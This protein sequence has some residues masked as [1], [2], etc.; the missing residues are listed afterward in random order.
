MGNSA[1]RLLR[2]IAL[3][4]EAGVPIIAVIM[5]FPVFIE[6]SAGATISGISVLLM[7]L[8]AIPLKNKIKMFLRS[9]SIPILWTVLFVI[10][11]AIS[12]IIKEMVVVTFVG[13]LANIVGILLEFIARCI[14]RR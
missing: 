13:M 8:C 7:I 1:S 6:R 14:D 4:I 3:V 11:L 12:N 2:I 9:P 5:Q 10:C